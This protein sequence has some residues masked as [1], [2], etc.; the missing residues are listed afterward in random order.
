LGRGKLVIDLYIVPLLPLLAMAI[1]AMV[2]IIHRDWLRKRLYKDF[3]VGLTVAA[4]AVLFIALPNRHYWRDET[5]NQEAAVTWIRKHVP[6][7]AIIATDNYLYPYLAQEGSYKNVS[8]FF[9]TE[10]DPEVRKTYENDWRNIDYLVLTHEVVKQIK[11]GTIPRMKQVLDHSVL[12]AD[13]RHDTSSYIDLPNYISTNGDW[14]Q[15][16]KIKSRNNIV[17]QDSWQHFKSTFVFDYGQVVDLTN[18]SL[19]SSGAQAQAMVRAVRE[20]DQAMFGGLWQWSKD[21]LRYRSGD[22]L[23]SWK[24]ELQPDGTYK[25]GD[26]N[27]VC[28]ADQQVAYALFMADEKWPGKGYGD[29]G[30]EHVNDWWRK[31]VFERG[32][33]IFVDSSAD[34]SQDIKVVNPGYFRPAMYAYFAEHVPELQWQ[35]LVDDGYVL[36]EQMYGQYR[37]I[38][39][40]AVVGLDGSVRSAV[41]L[42]G[43]SAD[44]F[45][46]DALQLVPNLAEAYALSQ[47]ARALAMLRY[48]QPPTDRFA[49]DTNSA[50]AQTARLL[51]AQ[52]FSI[53]P[54]DKTEVQRLYEAQIYDAYHPG[55][56]YWHNEKNYLDQV[57]SWYWHDIQNRLDQVMQVRLR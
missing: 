1:G 17:L 39:D 51:L 32:G 29:E 9:S 41:P 31:C 7:D 10:Y 27:A 46:Y 5:S 40:W 25:L 48:L 34:G 26:S 37:T 4:L 24:W 56:G 36:L 8:Y 13:Y 52:M 18:G 21:H 23:L 53:S 19:T 49:A 15:V 14:V 50:P 16:Y 43:A 11:T 57:W 44:S 38:P 20:G 3:F 54:A 28:D 55:A 12:L 22:K 35:R 42:V 47:D 45:G 30:R 33:R 2:A 6:S